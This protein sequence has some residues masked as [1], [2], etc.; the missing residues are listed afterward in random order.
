[1]NKPNPNRAANE[2]AIELLNQRLAENAVAGSPAAIEKQHQKKKLTIPERLDLLFD[3]GTARF[4]IG[5]FAAFGMYE[6]EG[7]I[8]SATV[9]T[10]IGKVSG[11]DCIVIAND[12]MVKSGTWFPLTIKKILRAQ[13]IGLENRLPLIYLVDSGGL[14]LPLQAES[15]P[16]REHGGR[17]FFNNARLSA[18]GVPQIAA[19]MG[20]CV[21]GGA[22]IPALCDELIMVKGTGGIFLGGPHLVKAAIGEVADIEQLGGS[23]THMRKSG[24]ADYEA[25][26]DPQCIELV[27]KLAA[28]W[29][30]APAGTYARE[31]AHNPGDDPGKIL[32]LLPADRRTPYDM[33]GILRCVIDAGSWNEY[34]EDY[35]QS[36][37]TG[38]A[39]IHGL[40]VGVVAN[41][42]AMAKNAQGEM[43]IGGVIYSDSADKAARFILNCNQKQTPLLFIQ[44]VTGFMVGTRA[45]QGGIIKDGAKL[46]NA[47]SNSRVPK[48]TL[49]VGNSYGAGNYA[50]CGRAFDPRFMIA[51]PTAKIAVMGGDQAADTILS[52]EKTKVKKEDLTPDR[53]KEILDK[54][55]KTYEDATTPYYAAA[56]LWIDAIIDPRK[57][58]EA[59]SHL[60]EIACRYDPPKDF[61]VGVFQV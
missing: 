21:A 41:Q 15:F 5:A 19:V 38:T 46:V 30:A 23:S 49:V 24:M 33:R 14:F 6:E 52:I 51:W 42:R 32:D 61:N 60:F 2:A 48:V 31:S 55:R 40:N 45:E 29:P 20:P 18:A 47:V 39:R 13:E 27:R 17:I 34:K 9:R 28:Q 59:L 22:Y 53:E 43:Q 7:K 26:E 44:D 3:P 58:R 4:E 11:R 36:L 10:V 35:G 8:T 25:D 16:D 54:I 1:M 12:S 37:L 50:L 57:T 56:R